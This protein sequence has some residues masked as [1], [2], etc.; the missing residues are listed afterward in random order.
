MK[1]IGT[2]EDTLTRVMV[3]R[4]E[5]DMEQIKRAFKDKYGKTLYSFIKVRERRGGE[6]GG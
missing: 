1:G 3:S 4:C 5:I 2:D 6:K